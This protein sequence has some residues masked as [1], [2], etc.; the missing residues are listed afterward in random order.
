M[1]RHLG[2]VL[3]LSQKDKDVLMPVIANL[4][5]KYCNE[6]SF[7]PHLTIYHS[8]N[9]NSLS[10]AIFAATKATKNIEPFTIESESFGYKDNW[11]KI[12]YLKIKPNQKINSIRMRIEKELHEE[13][14]S[15]FIPHISLMYKD[16]LSTN[17]RTEIVNRINLPSTFTIQGIQI[18][19]PGFDNND[20]RNYLRWEI[21]HTIDF[22]N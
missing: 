20:W 17:L 19:S 8:T 13:N 11:S 2:F 16:N 21:M 9:I 6:Q 7:E 10:E 18:L 12:L 1:T 5:R 4:Q 3:S 22:S 15:E 14:S